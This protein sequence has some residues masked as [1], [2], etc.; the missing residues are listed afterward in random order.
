MFKSKRFL[1]TL[2][3]GIIWLLGVLVFNQDA[4]SFAEGVCLIVAPFVIGQSYRPSTNNRKEIIENEI[5][6]N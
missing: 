1:A 3:A 4:V 6:D 2:V 5:K